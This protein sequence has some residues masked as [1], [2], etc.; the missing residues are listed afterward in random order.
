MR[1]QDAGPGAQD[2]GAGTLDPK[3]QDPQPKI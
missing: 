3:L 2:T 1:T